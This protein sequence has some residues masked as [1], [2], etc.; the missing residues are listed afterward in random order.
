M[1]VT[2]KWML[3]SAPLIPVPSK[4]SYP[5]K[6]IGVAMRVCLVADLILPE[7]ALV[8]GYVRALAGMMYSASILA[9]QQWGTAG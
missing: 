3:R 6:I 8:A 4:I 2:G 1:A 7:S 5:M 9:R